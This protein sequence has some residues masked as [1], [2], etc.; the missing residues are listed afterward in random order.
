ML[1]K[2]VFYCTYVAFQKL[3]AFTPLQSKRSKKE[4]E[5]EKQ[6]EKAFQ[7]AFKTASINKQKS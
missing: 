5:A 6:A 1:Q 3:N 2:N 7:P 4:K